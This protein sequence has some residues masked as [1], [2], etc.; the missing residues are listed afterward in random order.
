MLTCKRG[1]ETIGYFCCSF[2]LLGAQSFE[3]RH[4]KYEQTEKLHYFKLK[5]HIGV[6]PLVCYF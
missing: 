3:L 5:N 2:Y 1:I 6:K 4:Q